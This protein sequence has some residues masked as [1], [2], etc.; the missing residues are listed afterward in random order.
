M[1]GLA[2]AA[3]VGLTEAQAAARLRARPPERAPETS[4]SYRSIV[5]ANVFTVFNLILL[6]AGVAT[7]TLGDWRDAM[8]LGILVAN[9]TIGIT[10][11][12][13]AKR[14]LDG[15]AALVAPGATVL[16][17]GRPRRADVDGELR[18]GQDLTL[19]E[20]IL[21]GESE[22]VVRGPGN[23]L[24]SG[25]FVVEDAGR[26]EVTATG[27]ASHAQAITG[28]ARA[29]RHPRSP[30][31]LALNR[32]LL[33]LVAAMV[34]LGL[35]LGAG[36]ALRDRGT[37]EAVTTAVA[38][39]LALVPEG[40][41]LLAG[42][43]GRWRNVQRVAKLFVSKSRVR[44]RPPSHARHRGGSVPVPP[45]AP[46]PGVE[47]LDR[48]PRVP[49]GARPSSGRWEPP[50]TFLRDVARFAVPGGIGAAVGVEAGYVLAVEGAACPC[51]TH[52]RSQRRSC[53]PS[54]GSRSSPSNA[55]TGGARSSARR[56][57][58]RSP[59]PTPVRS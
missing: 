22:P 28:Q 32:L 42:L 53:S 39:T 7:L 14:A 12:I 48:H 16:R 56:C 33:A 9:T 55:A 6:V 50:A 17:D 49:A 8:F 38:G 47:P 20:A 52:G 51:A 37:D 45:A 35:V 23:A 15:L 27:R 57:A 18:D 4:R 31:E 36:L 5:L 41:L 26:H 46:E 40:L 43:T 1:T 10:Q 34:P 19:D 3:P 58:W 13:R 30:L 44:R 2:V 54:A 24:R 11:E 59:P 29:F 25:S 21:T